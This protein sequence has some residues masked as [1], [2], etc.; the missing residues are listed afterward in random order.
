MSIIKRVRSSLR[1][2]GS[3][4][5]SRK[6]HTES[7]PIS[8]DETIAEKLTFGPDFQGKAKQSLGAK[9]A[10]AGKA[11]SE[12]KS[13]SWNESAVETLIFGASE[14]ASP[15][16]QAVARQSTDSKRA[17][18]E[19]RDETSAST[20]EPLA[21]ETISRVE[22]AKALPKGRLELISARLAFARDPKF[23]NIAL[24]VLGGL[25]IAILTAVIMRYV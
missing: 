16:L 20:N 22:H 19:T 11:Y 25:G 5:F 14:S 8:W 24:P 18:S 6:E 23:L 10:F 4:G 15:D 9:G 13:R 3:K 7:E 21:E 2:L 12:S 1:N 17:S